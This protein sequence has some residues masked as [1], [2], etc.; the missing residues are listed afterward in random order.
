LPVQL[1]ECVGIPLH[2]NEEWQKCNC[3][4]CGGKAKRETDTMDTFVDSSWYY[5]RYLSA[6]DNKQLAD[7]NLTCKMMPV[8][9]YIGGKEHAV[10]HLYYAR[11]INHFLHEKGFVT[12]PEPFKRL[13]S[14]GMVMGKT[15]RVKGSGKYLTE[16]DVDM[17]DE[18]KGKAVEKATGNSV[19][20]M[21][22]KMSK[23]KFNGV[24]PNEMIENHGCDTTRLIMLADVA[25]SS[26]R[27][28]TEA[29]FP[30]IINWQKRL[31]LTLH[32]FKQ[33]RERFEEFKKS[34]EFDE[35]ERAL[36]EALN[37]YAS[38][39][40][41][42]YKYSHQLSVAISRMQAFTNAIRRATPDVEVLGGNYERALASQIIMLAPMAPHFASELWERFRSAK[43]RINE[44]SA[45]INWN[46]DV[47]SQRW[48][49]VDEN[50][51]VDFIIK[52]NNVVIVE[53]KIKCG[54]LNRMSEEQ[55]L[56][57]ALNE[58]KALE[59]LKGKQILKTNWLIH[60]DYEGI[61]TFY[62]DRSETRE[63][64]K[65]KL[66]EKLKQEN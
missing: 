33:K 25:P 15:Y 61:L 22:E 48:P 46:A 26:S 32:D 3:P 18:K 40:T 54:E 58:K 38:S 49:K 10:L 53:S 63:K 65:A 20:V 30:G 60:E 42:N 8:D 14:Q 24:D 19:V 2:Q 12:H 31:W 6:Q 62:I 47:F 17:V 43:N 34:N 64:Q 29:T 37:L 1:P 13:L 23:S 28:W 41:F 7:M 36:A 52:V 4:K 5:L 56:F 55:A 44:H 45:H 57:I 35:H 27:N 16:S 51:N 9:V 11:F 66:K 21:W 50:F 39:T 59:Y